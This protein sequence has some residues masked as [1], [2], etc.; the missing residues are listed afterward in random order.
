MKKIN[1]IT[2]HKMWLVGESFFAV[3]CKLNPMIASTPVNPTCDNFEKWYNEFCYYH[4][5]PR[6]GKYVHFYVVD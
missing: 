4:C 2:A 1:K 5:S 6:A 3:P